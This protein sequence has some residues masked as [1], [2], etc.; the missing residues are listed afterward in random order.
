MS[1]FE[2]INQSLDKKPSPWE[3]LRDCS[4]TKSPLKNVSFKRKINP[5]RLTKVIDGIF[6]SGFKPGSKDSFISKHRTR[7]N[8]REGMEICYII[9]C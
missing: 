2:Q 9:N 6:I 8:H 1:K 4:T 5:K 3:V 7:Y